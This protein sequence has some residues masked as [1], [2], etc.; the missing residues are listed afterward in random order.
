MR[1]VIGRD[2][3]ARTAHQ[4]AADTPGELLSDRVASLVREHQQTVARRRAAYQ[5]AE[6]R[7]RD[8]AIDRTLGLTA[9]RT[10]TWVGI[11]SRAT[12]S[13]VRR[14]PGEPGGGQ[15]RRVRC[16]TGGHPL[17]DGWGK[18]FPLLGVGSHRADAGHGW[19]RSAVVAGKL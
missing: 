8:R 19:L 1:T 11:G 2:E 14:P 6:R 17:T 9:P 18:D 10:E 3:R 12:T 15:C 5:K 7:Q 4:T 16:R 13:A